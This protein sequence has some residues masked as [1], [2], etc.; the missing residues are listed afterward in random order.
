MLIRR[1]LL[2]GAAMAS[3]ALTQQA[4]LVAHLDIGPEPSAKIRRS[5]ANSAAGDD[6]RPADGSKPWRGRCSV[7]PINHA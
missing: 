5:V 3:G 7:L 6:E 4:R 2:L 1:T